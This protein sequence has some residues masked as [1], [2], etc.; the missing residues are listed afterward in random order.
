MDYW[1]I[2]V[3]ASVRH[4]CDLDYDA[5]QDLADNHIELYG[6]LIELAQQIDHRCEQTISSARAGGKSNFISSLV[7]DSLIK[8]LETYIEFTRKV[9]GLSHRRVIL[10][11]VIPHGE[12]IFSLFEPHTELINRDKSPY[13]IEFGHRVLVIQ[14]R[15]GFIVKFSIMDHTTDEKMIVPI[16]K[17]LQ[18]HYRGRILPASFDRRFYTPENLTAL[19]KIIPL[20]C[21]PKKGNRGEEDQKREG[22]PFFGKARKWHAG[23]EPA[24]HALGSG[25]GLIICRD[26]KE[27]GYRRYVALGVLGRN[28]QVLGSL[29][30]KKAK[31]NQLPKAA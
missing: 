8:E 10:G 23:I 9:C 28:L 12:K 17:R 11:E 30:T 18:I 24:I 7:V 13:P 5:L 20:L 31:K 6:E 15:A 25:N 14:D 2:L 1:E 22:A 4:G 27:E 3:L 21:I 16:M 29:L 26:K 19:G